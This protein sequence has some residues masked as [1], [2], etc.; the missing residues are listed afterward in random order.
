LVIIGIPA[1][2]FA[3]QEKYSNEK[4][5]GFCKINYG[6]T[7]PLAEKAIVIK[8]SN[9]LSLYKWLSEKSQN[10][11]NDQAP[12]WNFCKYIIDE[13]GTLTYFLNSSV[14]PLGKEC[15]QALRL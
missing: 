13:N 5:A 12:T 14:S 8:N 4:I 11:W 10:G 6:V 9:Q 15:K 2:D 3:N 1:N 7:F